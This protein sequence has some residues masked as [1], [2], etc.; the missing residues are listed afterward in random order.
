MG[1]GKPRIIPETSGHTWRVTFPCGATADVK[2]DALGL[3]AGAHEESLDNIR[4]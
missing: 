1:H 2:L 3:I 4:R